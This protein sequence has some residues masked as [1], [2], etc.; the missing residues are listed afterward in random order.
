[1][2]KRQVKK[3]MKQLLNKPML[4]IR[5]CGLLSGYTCP[6]CGNRHV[7]EPYCRNCNQMLIYDECQR[8][9]SPLWKSNEEWERMARSVMK[10][11]IQ[12]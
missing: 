5:E 11:Y 12:N 8:N 6:R 4:A 10:Q 7:K 1:M 9:R 3:K 2:N